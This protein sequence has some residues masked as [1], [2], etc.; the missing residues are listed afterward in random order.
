MHAAWR[1]HWS[2]DLSGQGKLPPRPYIQKSELSKRSG[3]AR[4]FLIGKTTCKGRRM[5]SVKFLHA[6]SFPRAGI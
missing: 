4:A 5:I 3:Q 6:C 1:V 2:I